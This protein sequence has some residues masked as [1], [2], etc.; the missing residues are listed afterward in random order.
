MEKSL[1]ID[2]QVR[3]DSGT[4]SAK[5]VRKEGK[6]PAI[7]YGHKKDPVAITINR[8][9]FT[10]GLHHGHRLM[11][12]KVGSKKENVIVKD[13]QY[14]Y[15]GKEIIHADL[16]RVS[17][18]ERVKVNVPIVLKGT[19]KG[20][21]EG[22]IVEEHLSVLEIEC[23]VTNIPESITIRVDEL[24]VGDNLHA[25]E[26]ELPEGVK[27]LADSDALVVACH[28]VAAAIS[29][30]DLEEEEAPVAP[31]VIGEGKEEEGSEEGKES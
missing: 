11:E 10:E 9:N 16:M 25:G 29:A 14:D 31:E 7:M 2:A 1:I 13:I 6:I 19:A 18:T 5:C 15:L 21:E 23:V 20:A 22:G 3:K 17:V 28:L 30:G 27:L 24:D 26:I 12:I 8:H 4:H